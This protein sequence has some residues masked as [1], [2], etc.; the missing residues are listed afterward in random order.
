MGE[1]LITVGEIINTHGVTGAVRV[2]PHTDFPERFASMREA[3]VCVKDTQRVF[4]IEKTFPHKRFIIMKFREV[5]DM[6]AALALKGGLIQ[7]AR[8][9]VVALPP[10]HYYI[11]DIVGLDVFTVEG[12]RLGV[13][14]RVLR[15]GANDVYVVQGDGEEMYVP[16]LKSVVRA[17][18][19]EAHRMVVALPEGLR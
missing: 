5:N 19:L 2:L 7:V 18:D 13:V 8:D 1:E 4:T 14:S 16:A 17:I 6:N 12:E 9:E 3:R 15:T 11:F 10:G